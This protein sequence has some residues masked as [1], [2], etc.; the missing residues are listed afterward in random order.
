MLRIVAL[1]IATVALTMGSSGA[2]AQQAGGGGPEIGS[3]NASQSAG[4]SRE[5]QSSYNRMIGIIDPVK[6]APTGVKGATRPA[7]AADLK[8]GLPLRDI[9]G[10]P[11]GAVAK[12]E[13]DGV[14]VDT[15]KTKIK[16]PAEAFGRDDL[17][18]LLGI[19]A[20]KFAELVAKAR[21]SN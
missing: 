3:G 18:L 20:V 1:G 19:T 14:V 11:I 8:P 12:V 7:V 17:G 5:M 21:A 10:V 2:I 9:K 4:A 6:G 15:G 13:Q 16:V